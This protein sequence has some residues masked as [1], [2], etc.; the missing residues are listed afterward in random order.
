MSQIPCQRLLR[1]QKFQAFILDEILQVIDFFVAADQASR[2]IR[3]FSARD[4]IAFRMVSSTK[5][6]YPI[7]H[8]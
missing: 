8:S 4:F 6:S 2:Q 7:S 3:V 5:A 1:R